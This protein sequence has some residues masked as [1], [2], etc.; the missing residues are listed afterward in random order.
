MPSP[1]SWKWIAF[2]V[3]TILFG[4]SPYLF[5]LINL[6]IIKGSSDLNYYFFYIL[7]TVPAAIVILLI[8]LIIKSPVAR[9][10][11]GDNR[12]PQTLQEIDS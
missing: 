10:K 9:R 2:V 8:G 11:S 6:H 4:A 12:S 7:V 5:V 3:C 1:S